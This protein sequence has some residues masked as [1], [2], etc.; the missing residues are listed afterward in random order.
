MAKY[1]TIVIISGSLAIWIAPMES[2][3][4]L[5]KNKQLGMLTCSYDCS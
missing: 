5:Y 4:A 3:T 2:T 1:F